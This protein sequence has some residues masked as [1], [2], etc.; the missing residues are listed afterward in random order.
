MMMLIS[1]FVAILAVTFGVMMLAAGPSRHDKRVEQRLAV[2]QA[3][4]ARFD[5]I[6]GNTSS[7]LRSRSASRFGW[8]DTSFEKYS[9]WR[10]LQKFVTQAG[11]NSS[12]SG[13]AVQSAAM[14]VIGLLIALIGY[15]ELWVEIVAAGVMG[16]LPWMRIAWARS[17]RLK[18]FNKD[19]PEAID[20]MA[21]ALR[22]GHAMAGA[23]EMVG[24]SA[25]PATGKEFAE[26]FRQ[27]NFGLPLRDALLQMLDR[28]PS[29]DLRVLITAIIVQRET[30][31]NL[32]EVMD[33]TVFLIRERQRIQG[34][35]RTQTAQGRL[36]GWILSLM[37][38]GL[39]GILNLIDPGYSK[40]LVTDPLGRKLC[41]VGLGL[42]VL[43][44]LIIRQIVNGV[45]V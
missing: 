22:A 27:Q 17:R 16:S 29:P 1:G 36:T 14:A 26:V 32:V 15:P 40:I 41:Y 30:G 20:M 33:R 25:P 38:V 4:T 12:A 45:D 21:R 42:I 18:A 43:G 35:I 2:I 10:G 19:L 9:I 6:E 13:V 7:L 23:I 31:G 39:M 3:G 34:E 37:P 28:M 44:S 24:D 8:I 11:V 5:I